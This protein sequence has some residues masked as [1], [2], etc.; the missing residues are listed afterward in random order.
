MVAFRVYFFFGLNA[1][2]FLSIVSLILVFASSIFVMVK[3]IEA[4]NNF[5][6]AKQNGTITSNDLVNCDYIENSTVPNQIGGVFW[7]VINRLLIIFQVIIL[8]LSEVGWP[9]VFFDR[10]FPVLGPSFGLGALGIFQCLIGASVLS[11]RVDDFTL[12]AAFF[13]FS[14]GC[15]NMLLGLIFR[16]SA[17][18]RRSITSWRSEAKSVLPTT[19]NLDRA[20]SSSSSPSYVSSIYAE[21]QAAGP[22]EFGAMRN[23]SGKAGYG[24]GRQGEK[25]AGLKGFLISKP[26]ESLPR[27]APRPTSAPS[28]SSRAPSPVPQFQSS[29]TAL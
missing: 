2:R 14:L 23:G 27:Y 4:V 28:T 3:D 5:D 11:Q 1:V 29:G 6:A 26:M 18:A 10:F 24:F 9:A 16:E 22:T 21:K 12:V 17:K 19:T 20:A 8:V 15:L 13:L 7:A 25:A